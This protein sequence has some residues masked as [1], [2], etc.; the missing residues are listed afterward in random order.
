MMMIATGLTGLNLILFFK[1]NIGI[2]GENI[3]K[4]KTNNTDTEDV[5]AKFHDF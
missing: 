2:H 1:D 4:N 5:T 3:R